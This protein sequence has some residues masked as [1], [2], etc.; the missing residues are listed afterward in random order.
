MTDIE[1]E[2]EYMADLYQKAI[3]NG[4]DPD[5]DEFETTFI[6][7]E[8]ERWAI[9]DNDYLDA[10]AQRNKSDAWEEVKLHE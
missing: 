5:I 6:D 2:M 3:D 4:R 9:E 7:K 10:F 8:I 1:I